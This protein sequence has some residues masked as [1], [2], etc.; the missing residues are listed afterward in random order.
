[1]RRIVLSTLLTAGLIGCAVGPNYREPELKLPARFGGPPSTQP[2]TV[3][4]SQWWETFNDPMLDSLIERA[5][6]DNLDLRIAGARLR[7]ARAARGVVTADLLP[8]VNINGSYERRRRSSLGNQ[9]T[10]FGGTG[11]SSGSSRESG[12]WQAGFDSDWE[13]DVFGGVRRSVEAANADIQA[14][15]EDVRDVRVTLLA[16]VGR[17]YVELRGFQRQLA[18][19]RENLQAQQQ[20][21]E[22]TRSRFQSG[23]TSDLDV[24]RAE[25]QAR[26]TEA[27]I[28]AVET[29]AL[30]A[31]HR[32][33]VLIGQEPKALADELDRPQALPP[34]PPS[35]PPGLPS[36]LLRRRPDVR[37]AERQLAAATARIGA[38]VADW[39]PRFSLTGSLGRQGEQAKDLGRADSDYWS[40][41]PSVSWPLLDW[42]RIRSNIGVQNA[43]QQQALAQY[44]NTVLIALE[45]VENALVAYEKEQARRQSLS[46][47]VEANRRAVDLASQLYSRGLADFLNVLEAQRSMF[48]SQDALARSDALVS[49]NLVQLYKALGG[50]WEL[51][52]KDR[53]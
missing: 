35:V 19:N 14:S 21:L 41:G 32:L 10:N 17:N 18:F 39:F 44:E 4:I 16:E 53:K 2:A 37:R 15:I 42:G 8:Q 50:G 9:N 6:T 23:L 34:P 47:A 43:R 45:D 26:T 5:A 27:E 22:L 29:Q 24:A 3:A 49:A 1:M 46:A 13:I 51:D 40:V 12:L 28:P 38:A 52:E 25:A 7:E 20:T 31:M 48:I 30:A 36:E 11:S 33:A